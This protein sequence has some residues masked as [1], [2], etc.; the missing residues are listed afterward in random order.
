MG[1]IIAFDV[2][3]FFAPQSKIH[4]FITIGSPL[5][6]PLVISKIAAQYKNK[7]SGRKEMVNPPG[8]YGNWFNFSD[9]LV[10]KH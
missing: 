8:L 1:S 2:L 3:S 5:G 4:T 10:K 9:V 6:L 7:P